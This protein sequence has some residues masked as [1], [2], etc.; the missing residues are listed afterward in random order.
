MVLIRVDLPQPFGPRMATCSSPR[1]TRLKSF[2]TTLS[3]RI[4]E[5]FCKSS[6]A[7]SC[8]FIVL[9]LDDDWIPV[10][11]WRAFHGPPGAV[12]TWS[13]RY[14]AA[15]LQVDLSLDVSPDFSP[16]SLVCGGRHRPP[17]GGGGGLFLR[18]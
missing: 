14:P 10:H 8:R 15:R 2:R 18:S 16:A 4:T 5:I 3:P 13:V 9:S 6:R 11:D 17:A 1:I 7:G 12:P